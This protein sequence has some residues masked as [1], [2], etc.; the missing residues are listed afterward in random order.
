MLRGLRRRH[1]DVDVV[2]LP[3]LPA[4]VDPSTPAEAQD[5]L[6]RGRSALSHVEERLRREPSARVELWWRQDRPDVHRLVVRESFRD[7]DPDD[8]VQLLRDLGDALLD[9]GWSAGPATAPVPALEAASAEG[10]L[11][12]SARV[13]GGAVDVELVST[14]L[15]LAREQL[16]ELG[17]R[18]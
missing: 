9:H 7:L 5:L 18:R 11:E 1:P 6:A 13:V 10:D 15:R 8:A 16:P 3:E 17:A 2:V 4:A 12:V 14:P